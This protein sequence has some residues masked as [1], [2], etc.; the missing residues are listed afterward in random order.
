MSPDD[1]TSNLKP[2]ALAEPA[3]NPFDAVSAQGLLDAMPS[4]AVVVD[5]RVRI[6]AVNR[7]AAEFIGYNPAHSIGRPLEGIFRT[8]FDRFQRQQLGEADPLFEHHF[9]GSWYV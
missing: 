8:I 2:R 5:D 4:A 3:A 1:A 7:R 6:V 9:N